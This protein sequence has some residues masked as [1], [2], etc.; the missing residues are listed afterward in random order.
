MP[1]ARNVVALEDRSRLV[2][3]QRHGDALRHAIANEVTHRGAAKVVRD[4]P[5][6]AG[7]Q[8]SLEP[9]LNLI[10]IRV[11]DVRIGKAWSELAAT[12]QTA[13]GALD[14]TDDLVDVT[15]VHKPKAKMRDAAN[16]TGRGRV[17]DERQDVVSPRRPRVDQAI[18]RPYSR[19]PNTC[20]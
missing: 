10:A 14:L 3:G 1:S 15:R 12:E 6:A 8:S 13:S 11:G 17:F 9:D 16:R 5:R 2:A 19:R 7:G 20:S 4:S 18:P